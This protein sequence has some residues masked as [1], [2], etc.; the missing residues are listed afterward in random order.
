MALHELVSTLV[1]RESP[2][3]PLT[4]GNLGITTAKT[5]RKLMVKYVRS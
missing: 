2:L 3:L 1:I 5:A 4:E